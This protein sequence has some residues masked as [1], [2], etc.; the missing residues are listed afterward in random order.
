MKT[1]LLVLATCL[2]AVT[3]ALAQEPEGETPRQPDRTAEK[4]DAAKEEGEKKE[5]IKADTLKPYRTKGNTWTHKSTSK[6]ETTEVVSFTKYEVL[7]VTDEE[8]TVKMTTLDREK[9]ELGSTEFKQPLKSKDAD[10][11][12]SNP[13]AT[14][15]EEK[16]KVEGGEFNCIKTEV[17]TDGNVTTTWISKTD[18]LVVK[19]HSKSETIESTTELTEYKLS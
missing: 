2:W 7:E 1:L 12:A 19:I 14:Q 4:D 10:D 17:K 5:A 6:M 8:A 13:N 9:K 11:P 3:P 15:S 16:L 18:G